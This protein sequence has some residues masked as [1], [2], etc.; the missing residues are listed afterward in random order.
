MLPRVWSELADVVA[1]TLFIIFQKSWQSG[2]VPSDW[3]KGNT[4]PILKKGEMEDPGNYDQSASSLCPLRSQSR[5]F[6]KTCRNIW[7]TGR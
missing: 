1:K 4:P 2:K 6:W 5:S 3:K 7:R